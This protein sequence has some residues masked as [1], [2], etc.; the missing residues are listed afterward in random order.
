M[1]KKFHF[2]HAKYNFIFPDF[3]VKY[4]AYN[5]LDRYCEV[6]TIDFKSSTLIFF[7]NLPNLSAWV[8]YHAICFYIKH[9]PTSVQ[10]KRVHACIIVTIAKE[11]FI[12]FRGV[13]FWLLLDYFIYM[14]FCTASS[15]HCD[16]QTQDKTSVI[17]DKHRLDNNAWYSPQVSCLVLRT[18]C[19]R[20]QIIGA[21]APSTRSNSFFSPLLKTPKLLFIKF[22]CSL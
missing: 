1:Q 20:T 2:L 19:V 22:G 13:C 14:D 15:M 4:D 3:V 16:F 11:S 7:L 21:A 8:L 18:I 12:Y 9:W 17:S 10:V 6:H 5:I